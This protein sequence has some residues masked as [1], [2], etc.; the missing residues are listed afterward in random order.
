MCEKM[1][2]AAK[3]SVWLKLF[4]Y[5]LKVNIIANL[6]TSKPMQANLVMANLSWQISWQ[7]YA[8]KP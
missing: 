7:T 8:G 3:I 4:R 1:L 6:C 2:T 5:F